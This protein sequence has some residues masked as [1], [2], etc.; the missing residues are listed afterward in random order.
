MKCLIIAAGRGR[1]LSGLAESK[2][3]LE[4]GGRSLISRVIGAGHQAGIREFVVV[5]GYA[6]E[7]VERHLARIS[8][9]EDVSITFVRN[10][11]WEK[12]NGLSVLK[13]REAV[14]DRFLLTMSD[15]LFDP[16]IIGDLKAQPITDGETIL[17]VDRR[18]ADNPG[19]DLDDVTRVLIDDGRIAA[20]GKGILNFNAFDTGL[21]LGTPGLFRAL[22]ES[23]AKGDFTIS[24]GMKVLA[25]EGKA[26]IMD[27]D[28]RY[29]IDVDDEKAV[30]KAARW[31]E[32]RG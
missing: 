21:F 7:L 1:R 23:Q 2:P 3:L 10:D 28:G 14:G 30:E 27:I 12:E 25:T 17:A 5:T 20:I 31:I 13:A 22:G 29:W 26:R 16:E 19:V 15:H 32:R 9:E 4:I 18:T 11:E 6:A 8:G 24:G